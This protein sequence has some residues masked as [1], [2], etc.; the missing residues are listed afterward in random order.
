MDPTAWG[1]SLGPLFVQLQCGL[2][3]K[4]PGCRSYHCHND[5]GFADHAFDDG[6]RLRVGADERD[7]EA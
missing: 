5:D 2:E 6:H 4:H 3:L 7:A 1:N